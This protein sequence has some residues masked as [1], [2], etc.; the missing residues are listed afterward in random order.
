MTD[1][2]RDDWIALEKELGWTSRTTAERGGILG[3]EDSMVLLT[4]SGISGERLMQTMRIGLACDEANGGVNEIRDRV[5][6]DPW[7]FTL[8]IGG[9]DSYASFGYPSR[10]AAEIAMLKKFREGES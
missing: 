6:L 1:Q 4:A 7:Y 2:E 5:Q 9:R 3:S 8:R 10:P